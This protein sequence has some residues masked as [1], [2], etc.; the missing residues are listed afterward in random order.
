MFLFNN[1]ININN[2]NIPKKSFLNEYIFRKLKAMMRRES[3]FYDSMKILSGFIIAWFRIII[4]M[5]LL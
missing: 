3:S 5:E 4:L 1:N 2:K